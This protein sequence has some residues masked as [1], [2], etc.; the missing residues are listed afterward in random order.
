MQQMAA[1]TLQVGLTENY[2]GHAPGLPAGL[3]IRCGKANCDAAA[4]A[5]VLDRDLVVVQPPAARHRAVGLDAAHVVVVRAAACKDLAV[6]TGIGSALVFARQC[7]RTA[8][9]RWPSAC[10]IV[11]ARQELR[12]CSGRP[13]PRQSG[14]R[15]RRSRARI[16]DLGFRRARAAAYAASPP[17][18]L[19][20]S[21]VRAQ[22]TGIVHSE[23][24]FGHNE[25]RPGVAGV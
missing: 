18:Y 25:E 5:G 6:S 22:L 2:R 15:L 14:H 20:C 12:H 3:E 4:V 1:F 23:L 8:R 9:C 19:H 17:E 24:G 10:T 13:T 11:C 21:M 16:A 7:S